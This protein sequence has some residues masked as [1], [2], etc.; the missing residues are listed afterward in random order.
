MGRHRLLP[1]HGVVAHRPDL[2]GEHHL[3]AP[4]ARHP[5]QR[6][7]RAPEAGPRRLGRPLR[8]T[9]RQDDDRLPGGDAGATRV[10]RRHGLRAGPAGVPRTQPRAGRQLLARPRRPPAGRCRACRAGELLDPLGRDRDAAEAPLLAQRGRTAVQPRRRAQADGPHPAGGG[11][12]GDPGRV[13][14]RCGGADLAQLRGDSSHLLPAG[15]PGPALGHPAG[16]RR[17][18]GT[19]RLHRRH[20]GRDPVH[21]RRGPDAQRALGGRQGMAR[22][23]AALAGVPR[24]MRTRGEGDLRDA[25]VSRP[26]GLQDRR[27]D[28]RPVVR[29]LDPHPDRPY[30]G[31]AGELRDVLPQGHEGPLEAAHGGRRARVDRLGE[32]VGPFAARRRVRGHRVPRTPGRRVVAG[33]RAEGTALA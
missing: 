33:G 9:P 4:P 28:A 21:L 14:R 12:A 30:A 31:A 2:P 23:Q 25:G 27:C 16:H 8:L 10:R 15:R 26:G 29:D 11:A 3:G 13:V 24:G 5:T 19:H 32:P 7:A 1:V 6:G 20:P 17:R 22:T 18:R